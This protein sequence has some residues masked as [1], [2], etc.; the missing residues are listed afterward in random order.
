MEECIVQLN[1]EIEVVIMIHKEENF[2][3]IM[4]VKD[5]VLKMIIEYSY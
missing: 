2:K 4:L 3:T 1:K 5:Y